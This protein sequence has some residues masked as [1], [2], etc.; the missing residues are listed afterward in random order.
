MLAL[1]LEDLRTNGFKRRRFSCSGR[2]VKAEILLF[3][4]EKTTARTQ[5]E[6]RSLNFDLKMK[7]C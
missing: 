6:N 5:E 2:K 3:S 4:K 7:V 1:I